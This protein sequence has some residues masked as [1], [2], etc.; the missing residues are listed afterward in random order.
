MK[1]IIGLNPSRWKCSLPPTNK[2]KGLS[3]FAFNGDEPAKGKKDKKLRASKK[4]NSSIL[5]T[6]TS[7]QTNTFLFINR[8]SRQTG[9]YGET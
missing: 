8:K 4:F 5:L 7:K 3:F 6:L 2:H 9:H 1:P